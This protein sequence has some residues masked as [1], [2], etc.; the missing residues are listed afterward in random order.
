MTKGW[1]L[2]LGKENIR[3]NAVCPS[4]VLTQAYTD[5]L[6][7][8]GPNRIEEERKINELHILGRVA[9][10]E[11]VAAAIAFLASDEASF[12]TGSDLVVDG[13][14]LAR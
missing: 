7:A 8:F 14:L 9:K 10:A 11:E 12:I 13:G 5:Y 6:D 1:A 2:D 4:Y 3:V